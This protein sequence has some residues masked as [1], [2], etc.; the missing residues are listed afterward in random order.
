MR[1]EVFEGGQVKASGLDGFGEDGGGLDTGRDTEV[2]EHGGGEYSDGPPRACF[3]TVSVPTRYA[4]GSTSPMR[5]SYS[6]WCRS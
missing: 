2:N 3:S 6:A 4:S 1:G 5:S